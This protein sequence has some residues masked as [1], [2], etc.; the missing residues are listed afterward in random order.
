MS[1]R[2]MNGWLQVAAAAA[3]L[4]VGSPAAHAGNFQFGTMIRA[5]LAS[6]ADW[7]LGV[8]PSSSSTT[9]RVDKS[10][11][12]SGG[13]Q[14]FEIGYLNS[15]NTAYV[16]VYNGTTSSSGFNQASFNPVGGGGPVA[17]GTIWRLPAASFFVQAINPAGNSLIQLTSLTLSGVTG[18][19]SVIQPLSTTTM[20]AYQLPV[21]GIANPSVHQS[22]D[23]VFRADSGGN[24]KLTGQLSIVGLISGG[25][26]AQGNDLAF[27]VGA[28]SAA[29]PEPGS[30]ALLSMGV[31]G[32][33]AFARRRS[34][35]K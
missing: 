13:G 25:G 35:R 28:V 3:V 23:L 1:R 15:T 21:F 18:A 29:T 4:V 19:V 2:C 31:A 6:A 14:L 30:M 20:V 26:V 9:N 7:E 16:R 27:G 17:P 33:V 24:W 10:P 8:G 34:S 22:Q 32:M 12:Y 11:Y 5:G